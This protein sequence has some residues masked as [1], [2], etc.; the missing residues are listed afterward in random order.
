[1]KCYF[2]IFA[3]SIF[4]NFKWLLSKILC[5]NQ[6]FYNGFRGFL[7]SSTTLQILFI[8]ILLTV[9]Q[10]SFYFYFLFFE[11]STEMHFV[12]LFFL[13]V[14]NIVTSLLIALLKCTVVHYANLNSSS[15]NN[16]YLWVIE[17]AISFFFISYLCLFYGSFCQKLCEKTIIIFSY[18]LLK[19]FSRCSILHNLR[20]SNLV[21]LK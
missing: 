18:K 4:P 3:F 6:P 12:S 2:L 19:F 21:I 15:I 8:Y 17:Y 7:W 11:V 14:R 1:M 5:K 9:K 16:S 10:R 13:N 20:M